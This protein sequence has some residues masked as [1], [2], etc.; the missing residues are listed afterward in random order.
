MHSLLKEILDPPLLYQEICP[1]SFWFDV[2]VIVCPADSCSV[3]FS[4]LLSL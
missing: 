1:D 3:T 2:L 4:D